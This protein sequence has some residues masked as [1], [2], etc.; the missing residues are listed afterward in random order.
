MSNKQLK[1]G[2]L[3]P[4]ADYHRSNH[5][6]MNPE[7]TAA[8]WGDTGNLRARWNGEKRPPKEGEWYLSGATIEA[9]R[10]TCDMSEAYP[11]AEIVRIK[12]VIAD[13]VT[14]VLNG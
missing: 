12:R 13:V 6:L 11:I 7:L 14:E 1:R 5:P 3:Y 2:E 10:A 9:Y 8:S 4:L